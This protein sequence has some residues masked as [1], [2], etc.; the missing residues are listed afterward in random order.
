MQN[1]IF[2][3]TDDTQALTVHRVDEGGVVVVIEDDSFSEDRAVR[4]TDSQ[5]L[6]LVSALTGQKVTVRNQ[7]DNEAGT[8][9]GWL[10][11]VQWDD[12]AVEI[13]DVNDCNVAAHV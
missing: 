12:G 8:I 9:V 10:A 4:L 6:Q 7:I 5:V 3:A 2:T 11:R 13:S 1:E